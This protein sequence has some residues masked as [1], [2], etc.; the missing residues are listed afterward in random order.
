M[1]ESVKVNQNSLLQ[2]KYF[3]K[4]FVLRNTVQMY[5]ILVVDGGGPLKLALSFDLMVQNLSS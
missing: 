4:S 5:T 1:K 2:G 3:P